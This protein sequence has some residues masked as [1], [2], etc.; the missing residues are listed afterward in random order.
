MDKSEKDVQI[1]KSEKD[2]QQESLTAGNEEGAQEQQEQNTD[3]L[4]QTLDAATG[5]QQAQQEQDAEG[6]GQQPGPIPYE[7]FKEVIEQKRQAEEKAR[8][9]EQQMQMMLA[10]RQ[11]A[12]PPPAQEPTLP[13]IPTAEDVQRFVQ[14][15]EQ[16]LLQVVQQQQLTQQQLERYCQENPDLADKL[17][18]VDANVRRLLAEKPFLAQMP[19]VLVKEATDMTRAELKRI[20]EQAAEEARK[21]LA[22]ARA[23]SL[24]SKAETGIAAPAPKKPEGDMTPEEYLA[25]HP[26]ARNR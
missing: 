8:L 17:H 7:R 25:S 5:E 24:G 21:E 22:R 16:R 9:F 10:L 23:A 4:A 18:L 15:R 3:T 19:A 6:A 20:R 13:E 26:A 11:Q 14:M 1:E 2:V 12:T